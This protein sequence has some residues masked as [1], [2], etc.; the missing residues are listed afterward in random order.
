M[1]KSV[2]RLDFDKEQTKEIIY[3]VRQKRISGTVKICKDF[4]NFNN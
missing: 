3:E 1:I 4:I 2:K